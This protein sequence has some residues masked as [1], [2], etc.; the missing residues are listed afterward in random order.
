MPPQGLHRDTLYRIDRSTNSL[1]NI[2]RKNR[3]VLKASFAITLKNK[4]NPHHNDEDFYK[5]Q[6][7]KT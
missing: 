2:A 6:K 7:I 3:R 1:K 5:D 4:K